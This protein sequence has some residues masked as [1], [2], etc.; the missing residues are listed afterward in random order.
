MPGRRRRAGVAGTRPKVRRPRP[1][2][3]AIRRGGS[4]R[5]VTR[6]T[7][8]RQARRNLARQITSRP[9]PAVRPKTR[10]RRVMPVK[11]APARRPVAR[12]ARVARARPRLAQTLAGTAAA[13][14]LGALVLNVAAAHPQIAAESAAL[15]DSLDE[16]NAESSFGEL[17][18]EVL[19]LDTDLTH[20]LNLLESARQQGYRYQGNLD[21]IGHQVA[22]EWQALRAQIEAAI[23][24]EATAFQ[25]RLQ[26]LGG[27][28]HQLNASLSNPSRATPLLRTTQSEV[29]GLLGDVRQIRGQLESQ[30]AGLRART[31]ELNQRLTQIHWAL[32]QLEEAR[33][34][35][36]KGEDL[37]MAVP[38]RWDQAGDDDP[39]G[40]LFL[41][42]KRL[43]FERKEKQATKKVLFVTV[44]SEL[45]QEVLIDQPLKAIQSVKAASRGL[46]G[47]Q[48]F[49]EMAFQAADLQAV[50]F[51]LNGQ[52][53][54]AW[55]AL[56]ERARSGKIEAERVSGTGIS[57][58]ALS[59]PLT[60]AALLALQ[61]EVNALQDEMMLQ[62]VRQELEALENQVRNL[63]RTLGELRA[64]GY[65]IERNLEADIAVLVA[66]WERV[67]ANAETTLEH[68]TK[69]LGAQMTAI[70][71]ELAR[72]MGMAAELEAARPQY[73]RV[74]SMI[75]SAEA[76]AD[77]AED[78]VL[79]Q[80]DAYAEEVESLQSHL[81]WVDWMLDALATASFSLLATESGVA[82][83]EATWLRPNGDPENG[84]L[85]LTD[86][87]LLWEDRVG[88]YELK[89]EV[90]LQQI[91]S[92]KKEADEEDGG[93]V[94]HFTF[95]A[96]AP[97]PGARFRLVEPVGD[98]WLVMVGRA[99]AG[100]YVR[101]RAVEL[102]PQELARV[103]NAPVRCPN[104]GAAFTAP[105][106][107][108]QVEIL[109]E[110]CGV[111]TKI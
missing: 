1:A 105:I 13:A 88:D 91:A 10:P 57:A 66:Q 110:Y 16:L 97:S 6:R 43:I 81:A 86:Q 101:D 54:E 5:R 23:Q 47:H 35:L 75:A 104:C 34:A 62:D 53:S 107:R 64:R 15:Q 106:L 48:D 100:E 69:L 3:V 95:E 8:R 73:L 49:L 50:N 51:H 60:Q 63:E 76:Q 108:G 26:P 67:K 33:F 68:Q 89:V 41:S 38:A 9:R 27:S 74:R 44:V 55:A 65:A 92:L 70:Q 80:Y 71:E 2:A 37:V 29:N 7:V 82:A 36:E 84:V 96:G 24:H 46:F 21:E 102:D 30:F 25:T 83:T 93:E 31:A 52:D 72:L 98:A 40:V 39:E 59:G 19:R 4:V 17:Q 58:A 11:P 99:Q 45:V 87:R 42:D 14:A 20:A 77:A 109:C 85:F 103:R 90:P 61:G 22:G 94:L 28:L 78:T 56:I 12:A 32:A 79:A 18:A 111:A